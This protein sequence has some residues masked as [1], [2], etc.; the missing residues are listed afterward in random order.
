[1]TRS[2]PFDAIDAGLAALAS[3]PSVPASDD[4]EEALPPWGERMVSL[5]NRLKDR[6][7]AVRDATLAGEPP[8]LAAAVR[9]ALAETDDGERELVEDLSSGRF[10]E[11]CDALDRRRHPHRGTLPAAR[12]TP[13]ARRAARRPAARA[14]ARRGATRGSPDDDGGEPD[15]EPAVP[16]AS[17]LAARTTA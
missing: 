17:G 8:D 7:P 12:R 16:A 6:P 9:E 5:H 3:E 10:A 4:F 2:D 15:D 13:P 11:Q 14:A 1:M